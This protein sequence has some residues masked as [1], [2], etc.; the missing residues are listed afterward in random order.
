MGVIF[1]N[2][3]GEIH[4]IVNNILN[5]LFFSHFSI[6]FFL[7]CVSNIFCVIFVKHI[8]VNISGNAGDPCLAGVL[9]ANSDTWTQSLY[10]PSLIVTWIS[11][12]PTII[13][14]S[15]FWKIR[16]IPILTTI[17]SKFISSI[18][19]NRSESIN[20]LH[21]SRSCYIFLAIIF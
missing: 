2:F 19:N 3:R 4:G 11:S 15:F 6:T 1:C 14:F 16:I 12:Q 9:P 5:H 17:N 10:Q 21:H 18:N 7:F 8:P 20:H 13:F